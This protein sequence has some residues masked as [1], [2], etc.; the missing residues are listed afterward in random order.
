MTQPAPLASGLVRGLALVLLAAVFLRA[1]MLP[2][3]SLDSW[4]DWKYGQWIWDHKGLPEREPFSPYT[5][6]QRPV[7]DPSW[8]AEVTYYLVVTRAGP[9]GL[10]LLHALLETAKAGLFLLAV[11]R[12]T[13]SLG[14]AVAATLLMEAACW[15][16]F[17]AIRTTT[18]AEVCWA[19]LLL[20]CSGPVPSRAQIVA[21]PAVVA[22]WAN[23]GPTF[24]FGLI[25]LAGLLLGRFLQEARAR[26]SL[27][28][29][30]RD[31][32]VRRLALMLALAAVAACANPYGTALVKG[33]FALDA[34]P[35]P[36]ARLWGRL[37]PVQT[38]SSR[39][40]IASVLGVL[41]LLRL[42]PRRFTAAEVLLT[43]AFALGAWYDKRVAP[44]WL[45]LAPWLL[46]PHLQAVAG[47]GWRVAGEEA[48]SAPATRHPPPATLFGARCRAMFSITTTVS[49]MMRPI[50]T[51]RPPSDMRL[52]VSPVQYRNRNV[53][54]S[55]TGIARAEISVAR[56]L[57]RNT[58]RIRTL[59]SPPIRMASRTLSTAVCTNA[60]WS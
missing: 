57:R 4:A 3:A 33:A 9:E 28:A 25:L 16:F 38:R 58:S 44:W 23:L 2:V 1:N 37:V 36:S 31:P 47:G 17:D 13:G 5:D 11:R 53:I 42:S 26:R 54:A 56:Q 14:T 7:R 55:V 34:S 21:A 30:G 20:A 45:M 43:A 49:S 24:G 48:P 6:S 46:A 35:L 18:P 29:V 10:A 59:N 40:L 51:A 50:A 19:A 22:L 32:G 8:L 15:P 39:A 27:T 12:A 60:A 52:S 41:V